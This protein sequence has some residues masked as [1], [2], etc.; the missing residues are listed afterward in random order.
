[1]Y[2]AL[3]PTHSKLRE[4][5]PVLKSGHI[6]SETLSITIDSRVTGIG[7]SI[8]TLFCICAILYSAYS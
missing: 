2:V 4:V 1:M 3:K 6:S 7:N 5:G 8:N